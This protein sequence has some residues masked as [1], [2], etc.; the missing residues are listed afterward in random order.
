MAA[1]TAT[2]RSWRAGVQVRTVRPGTG[3]IGTSFTSDLF[4]L[5][6]R[7]IKKGQRDRHRAE[8]CEIVGR[9]VHRL[10]LYRHLIETGTHRPLLA[11]ITKPKR[12]KYRKGKPRPPR[13]RP[14]KVRTAFQFDDWTDVDFVYVGDWL[15]DCATSLDCFDF[16]QYGLPYI[17]EH[18]K[19]EIRDLY[20]EALRG[21]YHHTAEAGAA[22][23]T[24]RVVQ[25]QRCRVL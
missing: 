20:R 10:L 25:R 7:Q 11:A 9:H 8:L 23:I 4:G 14:K 12:R 22:T 17:T 18:W 1:D 5:G 15:V 3:G 13:G 6:G 21:H 24:N 19:A 2:R 16:N